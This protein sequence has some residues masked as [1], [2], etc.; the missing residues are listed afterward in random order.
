M[1]ESEECNVHSSQMKLQEIDKLSGELNSGGELQFHSLI[2]LLAISGC[3]T[4]PMG[5]DVQKRL[6]R[7]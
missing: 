4:R 3:G 1:S 6:A 7:A 5:F 2:D